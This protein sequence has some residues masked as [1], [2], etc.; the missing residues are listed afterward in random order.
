[1]LLTIAQ[2]GEAVTNVPK[3][4]NP[5]TTPLAK[6]C[7]VKESIKM[8]GR[9]GVA[10]NF[11]GE[12]AVTAQAESRVSKKAHAAEIGLFCQLEAVQEIAASTQAKSFEG[13]L[14]QIAIMADW[15]TAMDQES[16]N[17]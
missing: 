1:L 12:L 10:M 3:T 17:S 5:L 6:A 15:I 2:I 13:G 8:S 9:L 4:D 7:P 11:A 14:F 16:F